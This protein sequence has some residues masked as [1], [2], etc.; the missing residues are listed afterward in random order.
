MGQVGDRGWGRGVVLAGPVVRGDGR[1]R[2]LGYPTA[3]V[4]APAGEMPTEE[5]LPDGVYAGI[6]RRADGSLETAAISIGRRPTY[7]G[8]GAARLVEAFV[9]DAAPDLYDERVELLVGPLVRTQ[10]RFSSSEALVVQIAADVEEVRRL[11]A[12]MVVP[13]GW[14]QG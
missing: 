8:P 7:H 3:N 6:L 4:A 13:A 11:S 2:Q 12:S 9:L 10:A 5:E 14:H 1:G